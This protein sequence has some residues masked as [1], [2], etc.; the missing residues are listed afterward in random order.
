MRPDR[1]TQALIHVELLQAQG[2]HECLMTDP[3]H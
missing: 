1:L 2:I 3:P